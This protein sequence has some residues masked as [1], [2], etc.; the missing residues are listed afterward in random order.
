VALAELR[1]CVLPDVTLDIVANRNEHDARFWGITSGLF[2]TVAYGRNEGF[3]ISDPMFTPD[4][5]DLVP[6][7]WMANG[8]PSGM[9]TS[10]KNTMQF[11]VIH[12]LHD[13]HSFEPGLWYFPV[14]TR[15]GE[16][17]RV[18]EWVDDRIEARLRFTTSHDNPDLT[19]GYQ[20]G[21]RGIARAYCNGVLI[22]E[23]VTDIAR[24]VGYMASLLY[25][26]CPPAR[27]NETGR[28][29]MQIGQINATG[30]ESSLSDIPHLSHFTANLRADGSP[31][32]KSNLKRDWDDWYAWV[33]S[34][35]TS[36]A[37]YRRQNDLYSW[38]GLGQMRQELVS[39]DNGFLRYT[40]P[41]STEFKYAVGWQFAYYPLLS[42]PGIAAVTDRAY[43]TKV[44]YPDSAG[45]TLQFVHAERPDDRTTWSDPVAIATYKNDLNTPAL[46][47]Y[48]DGTVTCWY[49]AGGAQHASLST[50]DGRTWT[51]LTGMMGSTLRNVA[52]TQHH[53]IT[54]GVGV[55]GGNLYFVRSNDQGRTQDG[56]PGGSAMQLVGACAADC[57]PAITWY[58]D[59]E[60]AVWAEDASGNEIT[61]VNASSGY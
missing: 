59:G 41:G 36:S 43:R 58:P 2:D 12:Q 9:W 46:A 8:C 33:S 56:I 14:D 18:L 37:N 13:G 30:W 49:M 3:F 29:V 35:W 31:Y 47:A 27:W 1:A 25:V 11:K 4:Y 40:A 32:I 57:R 17:V 44:A 24:W 52:V 6:H 60:V 54:L 5:Y 16:P 28:E 10:V 26:R 39:V 48:E 7:S 51:E 42:R 19:D 55:S 53:G 50:D 20:S 15:K 34:N 23:F 38:P 21:G 61:Y 45:A 22:E